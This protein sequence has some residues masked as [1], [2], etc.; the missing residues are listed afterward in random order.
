MG[1]LNSRPLVSS[2]LSQVH[3][4]EKERRAQEALLEEARLQMDEL[5]DELQVAE[6]ARLRLEVGG[7]ALRAQHERD[8]QAVDQAAEEQR[9][10]LLRQVATTEQRPGAVFTKLFILP[11]RCSYLALNV[12]T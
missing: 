4:L 12:F 2:G 1:A 3:H 9:R 11:L 10:Q 7:Q 5:E 6:D 8:L